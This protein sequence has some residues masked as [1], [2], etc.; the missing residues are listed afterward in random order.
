MCILIKNIRGYRTGKPGERRQKRTHSLFIDDL[1]VY[2]ENY[3]RLEVVNE[4]IVPASQMRML[5]SIK[6]SQENVME[7][8]NAWNRF[9]KR[10]YD[11]R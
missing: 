9:Q 11:K 5:W 10:K 4:M 7:Y 6:M 3:K 8:Q 1:K 2:Q